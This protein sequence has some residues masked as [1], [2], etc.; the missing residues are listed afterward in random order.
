MMSCYVKLPAK[1]L[2]EPFRE[3]FTKPRVTV[4]ERGLYQLLLSSLL[5]QSLNIVLQST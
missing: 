4:C 2:N 3:R 5:L 1:V